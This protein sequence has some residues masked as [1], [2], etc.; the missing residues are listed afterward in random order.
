MSGIPSTGRK[1]RVIIADDHA[2]LRDSLQ[3][4]LALAPDMEVVAAVQTADAAIDAVRTANPD[5]ILMDIDMPGMD[6]FDAARRIRASHPN[7]RVIF[8]SAFMHDRYVEQAL[9]AGASGYVTKGDPGDAILRAIRS[10]AAGNSAFSPAIQ[11]RIV[12][13]NDGPRL[14]ETVKTTASTISARELEVLR[15][16]ARGLTN[17]EIAAKMTLST[18]TVDRHVSRLMTKLDIHDR[19]SL[20]RYAIREGLVDA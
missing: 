8:L 3:S 17:K 9:R 18:R 4:Y 13:G 14:G 6:C 2:V 12:V 10:V 16:I 19:V 7:I 11:A 5:V 15:Q 1:T 20:A